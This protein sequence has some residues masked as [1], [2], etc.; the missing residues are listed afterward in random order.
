MLFYSINSLAYSSQIDSIQAVYL[1]AKGNA[2]VDA[3]LEYARSLVTSDSS[4]TIDLFKEAS[5]QAQKNNYIDGE[6]K[7]LQYWGFYYFEYLHNREKAIPLYK[8]VIQLAYEHKRYD[9]LFN[10]YNYLSDVYQFVGDYAE[11]INILNEAQKSA[12][13]FNLPVKLRDIYAGL[14]GCYGG[15][16]DYEKADLYFQKAFE[17]SKNDKNELW[18]LYSTIA[19]IKRQQK[20]TEE[21]LSFLNK[22]IKIGIELNH[23]YNVLN[24]QSKVDL[25][26]KTNR[27]DEAEV[28]CWKI[29]PQ[30]ANIPAFDFVGSNNASL[31]YIYLARKQYKKALTYTLLSYKETQA[32]NNDENLIELDSTLSTIYERM[33]DYKNSLYYI[34]HYNKLQDEI[35]SNTKLKEFQ[36]LQARF[37]LERQQFE[38]KSIESSKRMYSIISVILFISLILGTVVFIIK[39]KN[40]ELKVKLLDE[41]TK[42]EE[43]LREN[44]QLEMDTKTRELTSMAMAIDQK[45]LLW[46]NIQQ[47]L[48]ETLNS[49]PSISEQEAKSIFKIITQDTDSQHDWDTFKL[50]FE[51]VHPQFFTTLSQIAPNLTQLELRQCAYIKI[52]LATKQVANLLNITPD[53][54]KK[55]RMRIKKKLNLSAED[56]LSKF[57]ANLKMV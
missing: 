2:K 42:N 5:L 30:M 44:M 28:L 9:A 38:V 32:T 55:S 50:H 49:M 8:K 43:Q 24:L 31:G 40:N 20:K 11:A 45:N 4:K 34:N 35:Y 47:K 46:K 36:N 23:Y 22:S 26:I 15:M 52:N 21:A 27:I 14:M 17:L 37:S 3:A 53:S 18:Y 56:N 1:K 19:D 13:L 25:L 6:I 54:V 7:A 51:S 41:T 57:I 12:E 48:K 16:K 33:G 39:Q 29:R 10:T